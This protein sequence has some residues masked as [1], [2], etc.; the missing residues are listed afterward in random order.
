M[1][2]STTFEEANSNFKNW[3]RQ[4]SRWIKGYM[5]TTL[6]Y[7]RNPLR[8][9]RSVGLKDGLGFALLVGGT[10]V[11]FLFT[12]PAWGLFVAWLVIGLPLDDRYPGTVLDV[13]LANLILGNVLMVAVNALGV[14][15][16]R[17]YDLLV[18]AL[19][20]P[21]YWML[22]SVAAYKA[23]WQ[24]IK[25]PFYWEKT[26]HGL[27]GEDEPEVVETEIA[28]KRAIAPVPAA[29]T[30]MQ[31]DSVGSIRTVLPSRTVV[32]ADG[33][34]LPEK[35]V[36]LRPDV[37]VEAPL[38]VVADASSVTPV[39]AQGGAA[40]NWRDDASRAYGTIASLVRRRDAGAELPDAPTGHSDEV[41]DAAEVVDTPTAARA[42]EDDSPDEKAA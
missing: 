9:M 22:H 6:V 8:F 32:A 38:V 30:I 26:D 3:L 19:A 36:A 2:E 18:F 4:R 34:P 5:Q 33:A 20:N 10:P 41:I 14:T 42:Q 23:A 21:V 16:R 7:T 1:L 29:G 24:L 37:V 12:L 31:A 40:W 13:G 28:A 25:N 15:R 39:W 11:T 27:A 17:N 35:V